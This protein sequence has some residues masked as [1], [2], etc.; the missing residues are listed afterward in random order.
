MT[1]NKIQ[2]IGKGI[3]SKVYRLNEH[4]VLIK[5]NDPVK[6][7]MALFIDSFLVPK[8][9]SLDNNDYTMEYFA[10][11]KSLKESLFPDQ[12]QLYKELRA[13]SVGYVANSNDLY[14]EW[15]KQFETISNEDVREDLLQVMGCLADY[16]SDISFE[17]SPR[18]VAVK[19]G[20]LILLDCFFLKGHLQQVRSSK[21]KRQYNY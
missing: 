16:G 14:F 8:L 17:I 1:T 12:Y 21:K 9:N 4:E 19:D 10:P 3:F 6:E 15:C 18:N 13:L 2:L 11:V 20:K 7:C 5:S